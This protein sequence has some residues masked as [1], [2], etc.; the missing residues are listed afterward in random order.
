MDGRGTARRW[1]V[2]TAGAVLAAVALT[3]CGGG[4]GD[5][6]PGAKAAEGRKGGGEARK[7]ARRAFDPPV[8]FEGNAVDLT[9]AGQPSTSSGEALRPAVTLVDGVAYIAAGDGLEA[10]DT[11]TGDTKWYVDTKNEAD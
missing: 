10:V 1:G 3:G 9:G 6:A 7:P 8:R 4:G 11:L 5:G 2:V